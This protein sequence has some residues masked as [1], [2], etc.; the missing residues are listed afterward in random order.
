M[1]AR[2]GWAEQERRLRG[3]RG[4]LSRVQE[5]RQWVENYLRK[6]Q[7]AGYLNLRFH[8]GC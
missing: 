4:G 7:K 8:R 6:G 5:E 2:R 1:E 3:R